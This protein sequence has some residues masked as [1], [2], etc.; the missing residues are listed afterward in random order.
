MN[1][2]RPTRRTAALV[3]LAASALVVATVAAVLFGV[4]YPGPFRQ[5]SGGITLFFILAGVDVVL[6][7]LLT[8]VVFNPAKSRRELATDLGVVVLLQAGAL[9]YGVWTMAA[10][11]PVWLAFEVDL[12]RV[13][14]AVDVDEQLLSEAPAAL[15]QLSWTGPG[16]VGTDKPVGDR[17]I[18]ATM[19]GLHGVHLAMQPRYWVPFDPQRAQVWARGQ[20]YAE[21]PERVRRDLAARLQYWPGELRPPPQEL[22]WLPVVSARASWTV[23]VDRNGSPVAFAPFDAP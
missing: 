3:H 23:F 4:W 2:T 17:Q 20:T 10:A 11:R 16:L 1:P 19:L 21:L 9:A 18:E 8:A 14:S 6:G 7:P 5:L 12:F 13:V 22:R 15:R